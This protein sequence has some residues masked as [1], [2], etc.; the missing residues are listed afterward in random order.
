MP[1][2][3]CSTTNAEMPRCPFARSVTAI[4]T[5]TPPMRA[6][7]DEALRAVEHPAVALA[8]RPSSAS[9]AASLP[10]LASVRPQAPSTS[11]CDQPR[12]VLLLLRVV[13]EHRD[14]RRA[15]PV[16][17]RDRQR[18]R[19]TDAGELLD[20]DAVVDGRH[21]RAAVLLGK[22]DAHQAERRE[23]RQ[24]RPSGNAA[25]RPTP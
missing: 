25:P 11:P 3:P 13:A 14:V 1:G 15:Q 22:L 7:G 23:L 6:V 4:T 8:R 5:I 17:R 21:R 24:Q 2:V 10:A 9:P 16:V 20:A 18:D 12:Q 19:R